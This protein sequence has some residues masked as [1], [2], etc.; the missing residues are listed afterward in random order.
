[1]FRFV[2][3]FVLFRSTSVF[4]VLRTSDTSDMSDTTS[5]TTTEEGTAGKLNITFSDRPCMLAVVLTTRVH[6]SQS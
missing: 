2:L 1:M 4:F 3:F 6:K 5:A